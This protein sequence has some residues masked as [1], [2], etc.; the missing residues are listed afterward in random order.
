MT[1]RCVIVR[2]VWLT[3]SP[4]PASCCTEL[5]V[6]S[7]SLPRVYVSASVADEISYLIIVLFVSGLTHEAGVIRV[8]VRCPAHWLCSAPQHWR[9]KH[10]RDV[11]WWWRRCDVVTE[12]WP[13]EDVHHCCSWWR[14]DWQEESAK[15][16]GEWC[17][18]VIIVAL[19]L[20][21]MMSQQSVELI[22]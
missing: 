4:A 12:R 13:D 10:Q 16:E 2:P 1:D 5:I 19:L 22:R 7:C 17:R 20:S 14:Q 3:I 15:T 6:P 21:A 18:L 8:V 11:E 9:C